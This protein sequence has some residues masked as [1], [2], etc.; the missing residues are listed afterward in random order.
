LVKK[1]KSVQ[2]SL[3]AAKEANRAIKDMIK[4]KMTKYSKRELVHN[5]K[6]IVCAM[7]NTGRF[8]EVFKNFIYDT[9]D[10]SNPPL[11]NNY[12]NSSASYNLLSQAG[13]LRFPNTLRFVIANSSN[14][15]NLI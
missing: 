13:N 11:N 3:S 14:E 1:D 4:I 9:I 6:L 2:L 10:K 15:D 7:E 8:S 5:A 12:T